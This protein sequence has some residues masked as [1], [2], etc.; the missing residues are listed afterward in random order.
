MHRPDS[1]YYMYSLG[2]FA[3]CFYY[4]FY[5]THTFEF[6]IQCKVL[7]DLTN[8]PSG[9]N[10]RDVVSPTTVSPEIELPSSWAPEL[11]VVVEVRDM[12]Y[13]SHSNRTEWT[14]TDPDVMNG[15]KPMQMTLNFADL[16]ATDQ[17]GE[18]KF[19][20]G[21]RAFYEITIAGENTLSF[22]TRGFF[23]QEGYQQPAKTTDSK[24]IMIAVFATLGAL[25]LVGGLCYWCKQR[26][27]EIEKIKGNTRESMLI[28]TH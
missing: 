28:K 16:M 13:L 15:L 1:D 19:V 12:K 3:P 24:K 14:T 18:T 9:Y 17:A 8:L 26:Q 23:D 6:F 4:D 11:T 22:M 10:Y 7:T 5:A 20:N 2:G 27:D 21:G 25:L